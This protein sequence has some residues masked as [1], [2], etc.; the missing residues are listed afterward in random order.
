M[1]NLIVSGNGYV[2]GYRII[3]LRTYVFALHSK[4]FQFDCSRKHVEPKKKKVFHRFYLFIDSNRTHAG[5]VEV[6]SL[7]KILSI[8]LFIRWKS[9]FSV[10]ADGI[11]TKTKR[12][13][14]CVVVTLRG[15]GFSLSTGSASSIYQRIEHIARRI[16]RE[17]NAECCQSPIHAASTSSRFAYDL[18]I[19][20]AMHYAMMPHIRTACIHGTIHLLTSHATRHRA[21]M[22]THTQCS[23]QNQWLQ[24]Y[25][26]FCAARKK[27][28]SP[29]VCNAVHRWK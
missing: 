26:I 21:T 8:E 17:A 2:F 29:L 27:S 23:E 6:S 1:N 15:N 11:R 24:I 28:F 16:K 14:K 3:L 7:S 12:K 25:P 20:C 18:H 5:G 22:H 13:A 19:I 9:D 10:R 4:S